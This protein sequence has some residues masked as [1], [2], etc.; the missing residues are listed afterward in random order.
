MKT[1]KIIGLFFLIVLPFISNSKDVE[2][3]KYTW[4]ECKKF[5]LQPIELPDGQFIMPQD[6]G[7]HF[8]IKNKP[9]VSRDVTAEEVKKFFSE[10]KTKAERVFNSLM[11]LS[12]VG[13]LPIII[14]KQIGGTIYEFGLSEITFT[15]GGNSLSMFAM[16]TTVD[17]KKI[18][19]AGD[20][21]GFTGQGG[22]KEGVLN[23]VLEKNNNGIKLLKLEKVTL[24][25]TGG[26]L[27]F[28]CEGFRDFSIAGK[29]IF[30]R[31][32]LVPENIETGEP[33]EG[34]VN[35][36]FVLENITDFNNMLIQI[37]MQAFQLP[38]MKGFGFDVQ[39]AVIDVSDS[40]NASNLAFP[41]DYLAAEN[42]E[43][44]RGVYI[45]NVNVRF[46]KTFKNRVKKN[47]IV[48]GVKNLLI[49]R[50]GV[51]GE[52]FGQ[53]IIGIKEGDLN[54]WDYSISGASII[55]VKSQV[56]AGS[57]MGQM[58]VSVSSEEKLLG[59]N[60]IIDPTKDFYNFTIKTKDTLD[61]S[62]L[63]ATKVELKPNSAISL[64]LEKGEFKASALLHGKM[65][66][67][68]LKQGVSLQEL[69]FQDFFISTSAPYLSIGYFGSG[70]N[71]KQ[72]L[73]NFPINLNSPVILVKNN[74]ALINLGLTVNLDNVGISAA[75]GITIEGSFVNRDNRHFWEPKKFTINTIFVEANLGSNVGS[76]SGELN[77]FSDDPVYGTGFAGKKMNLK[78][79]APSVSVSAV[80]VFGIKQERYW[81]IDGML[82]TEG[83]KNNYLS[84]N[85]LAG[86]LYKKMKPVGVGGNGI[87]SISGVTYAPD[88]N[89]GWGG[90]FGVGLSV[91]GGQ[92]INVLAGLEIVTRANGS[93]SNIGIMGSASVGGSGI[94]YTPEKAK[95]L[96]QMISSESD[97]MKPGGIAERNEDPSDGQNVSASEKFNDPSNEIG[98]SA[99]VILKINFNDQSYYGKV[100]VGVSTGTFQLQAVGAFLFAPNK[101][102]VHL[103][104][105]PMHSRIIVKVP[106]PIPKI[107]GYIM[108]GHGM[109]ELPR[110][111]PDIFTKYPAKRKE[112]T[113][114]I[115][116]GQIASGKGIAFGAALELS[117]SGGFPR[118]KPILEYLVSV[119]AGMDMMLMRYGSGAYCLGREGQPIGLN[120]WRAAGQVYAIG[121]LNASAFGFIVIDIGLGSL[122]R[123]KTPNPTYA[124]GEVAVSFKVLYKKYSFNAGFQI[125]EE[126][127]V[128]D[129]PVQVQAQTENIITG[130]FPSNDANEIDENTKPYITF[131]K[132]IE[133]EIPMEGIDGKARLKVKYY[134][135]T[136][137]DGNNIEGSWQASGTQVNFIPKDQ[138]PGGKIKVSIAAVVETM[139]EGTWKPYLLDGQELSTN[140]EYY[141]TTSAFAAAK[142]EIKKE[143]VKVE[144]SIAQK[145]ESI[146]QNFDDSQKKYEKDA[147]TTIKK[148][149]DG[150]NSFNDSATS[151]TNSSVSALPGYDTSE[152]PVK[153]AINENIDNASENSAE[154]QIKTIEKNKAIFNQALKETSDI[155]EKAKID[156]QVVEDRAKDTDIPKVNS[157]YENALDGIK[158]KLED[159]ILEINKQ[160]DQQM[161][162]IMY[163]SDSNEDKEYFKISFDESYRRTIND[164]KVR[165]SN[166]IDTEKTKTLGML[167]SIETDVKKS[168]EEIY[169]NAK[170][171]CIAIM[172]KAEKEAG[173]NFQAALDSCARIMS[174]AVSKSNELLNGKKLTP[175]KLEEIKQRYLAA[176]SKNVLKDP[177]GQNIQSSTTPA[178][179]PIVANPVVPNPAAITP[180]ETK[181]DVI[182]STPTTQ[183]NNE[184]K[185]NDEI[186]SPSQTNGNQIYSIAG[187]ESKESAPNE[188]ESIAEKLDQER[189]RIQNNAE[190]ERQRAEWELAKSDRIRIEQ[191]KEAQDLMAR[192][193]MYR[194]IEL[195]NLKAQQDELNAQN[196]R[197][198]IQ[199]EAEL[200]RQ[201][202]A[203]ELA[204]NNRIRIEQ[205]KAAQEQRNR[206][207]EQYDLKV[208][209]EEARAQKERETYWLME[210]EN[211]RREQEAAALAARQYEEQQARNLNAYQQAIDYDVY[212][213]QG[214]PMVNPTTNNY[215]NYNTNYDFSNLVFAW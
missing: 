19:F 68:S 209:E 28:D 197:I 69:S 184:A 32:L 149:Q 65:N 23:L 139:N 138:L 154:V 42:D 67:V 187:A 62:F 101:W 50:F 186:Q 191:E 61:F 58:R 63:N 153:E 170:K 109:E 49:D 113:A 142:Q 2:S 110:P 115:N 204:E 107:D 92:A 173:A 47:R 35:S 183:S 91:N 10:A 199:N 125:G 208:R 81:F 24:E 151:V 82:T 171:L 175:E 205:E 146:I 25:L 177:F 127:E 207:R 98:F 39:N 9:T 11:S 83:D 131:S 43:A 164:A 212:N 193:K 85:L 169:C 48:A 201:R 106:L 126:C 185:G 215:N 93:I 181:Q 189:I 182:N 163:S 96:Y 34:N 118:N 121:Q 122:L 4:D 99:S 130:N 214:Q 213:M 165:A 143:A 33:A 111:E 158:K 54:G 44:W 80:A 178:Q 1:I 56:K 104:E 90:R 129:G 78:L 195:Y 95:E 73:G 40:Q 84:I 179:P 7:K 41:K 174:E 57:L 45:G 133:K 124:T 46:P 196:E 6:D 137:N 172:E 162:G 167:N 140:K 112:R 76:F 15:P 147:E 134:T 26:S 155:M 22:L 200:Q 87:Q 160:Y 141:F 52:I 36:A 145:T 202:A 156:L 117:S 59:Y 21:I 27:R 168:Q 188:A 37:N 120:Q 86:C 12:Y 74:A 53:N 3:K 206:E 190:M 136:D 176:G 148:Q 88:L 72:L 150:F 194:D 71:N 38:N 161:L 132:E 51:S 97:L 20:Q 135:L 55:L 192:E 144:A 14:E 180:Q 16:I 77:F 128:L 203:S 13:T 159:E 100:G 60:A 75:G 5:G 211:Q 66:I 89:V 114:D 79:K 157:D 30:D 102:F 64:K 17:G 116:S 31:S 119:R 105:P 18:C 94:N 70:S 166:A 152:E 103:G 29:V 8:F 108:L 210:Q 198:R 123:G